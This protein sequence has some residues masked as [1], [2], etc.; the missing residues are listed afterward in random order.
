[1]RT[2]HKCNYSEFMDSDGQTVSIHITGKTLLVALGVLVIFIACVWVLM[3]KPKST[4]VSAQKGGASAV[5]TLAGPQVGSKTATIVSGATGGTVTVTTPQRTQVSEKVLPVTKT[6]NSYY[7]NGKQVDPNA[8]GCTS[9][10]GEIFSTAP[11]TLNS[12]GQDQSR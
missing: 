9:D 2:K 1:M 11:Q 7:C 12:S 6:G 10:G 5:Q 4:A 8:T 3:M